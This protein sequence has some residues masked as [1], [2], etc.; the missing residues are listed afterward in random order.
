L[1]E[2]IAGV[3]RQGQPADR[4]RTYNQQRL[5]EWQQLL[6]L[7]GGLKSDSR[8]DPWI[9]Q[10]SARLLPCLP[11]TGSELASLVQL[12]GLRLA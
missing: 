10:C 7:D 12:L 4:L 1:T 5:A 8:T 9:R 6:G 11:A 2:I 3:L